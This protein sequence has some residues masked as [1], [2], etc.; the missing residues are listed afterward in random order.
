MKKPSKN[1]K[2]FSQDPITIL[3]INHFPLNKGNHA[4]LRTMIKTIYQFNKSI[5]IVVSSY[6]EHLTRKR[7]KVESFMWP[8]NV[9]KI[10]QKKSIFLQAII[11][12]KEII[13]SLMVLYLPRFSKK[14]EEIYGYYKKADI[15]VCPGGH[16]FTS[17]NPLISVWTYTISILIA[18]KVS[19]PVIGLSQTVGPFN[20][21]SGGIS[22]YISKMGIKNMDL[23]M[24]RDK[25]S[26]RALRDLQLENINYA[27]AGDIVYLLNKAVKG[28]EYN[29][30]EIKR[31]KVNI[32]VT[33]HHLYFKYYM[34]REKYVKIMSTFCNQLTS[35]FQDIH[36]IFIPMEYTKEGPKDRTLIC[37]I[38]ER[39]KE[40]ESTEMVERDLQP[41]EILSFMKQLDFFVGTKTHSIV[42]SLLS[43]TPTLSI[44]YH[45]KS[46]FFM[47]EWGV[48]E[49]TINLEDI[50]NE[51]LLELFKKLYD[52][53]KQVRT[54]LKNSRAI[55]EAYAYKNF[56]A[57][58]NKL[59]T[60]R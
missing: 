47:E 31:G 51:R 38:M 32:G 6:D 58:Q 8:V 43:G 52:N 25:S 33:I 40:K 27:F 16:L 57:I 60:N 42:M 37:E 21:I 19:K 56:E 54:T 28:E 41:E 44:S 7:D 15:I 10:V 53:S 14:S 13:S 45:E 49:Y 26:E 35:D 29:F 12:I 18:K 59:N 22:K 5:K 30:E 48:G 11:A 20:G 36:I 24:L 3:I 55:M 23:I 34:S 50:N 1:I 4:V 2:T 39:I 17:M 9:K 46:N